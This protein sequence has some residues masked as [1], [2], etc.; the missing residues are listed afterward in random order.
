MRRLRPAGKI[1][2]C[3]DPLVDMKSKHLAP[4]RSWGARV[5]EVTTAVAAE[6]NNYNNNSCCI[7]STDHVQVFLTPDVIYTCDNSPH[8]HH[9]T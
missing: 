9:I 2:D 1:C 6:A 8:D 3:W 7:K 5:M 4:S